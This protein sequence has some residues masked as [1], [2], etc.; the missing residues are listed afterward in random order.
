MKIWEEN[1]W[2]L[3]LRSLGTLG[4]LIKGNNLVMKRDFI[5]NGGFNFLINSLK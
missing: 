3:R 1:D 2:L 5:E 4:A